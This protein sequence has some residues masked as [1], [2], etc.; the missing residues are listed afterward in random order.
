MLCRG[1]NLAKTKS[2]N[3]ISVADIIPIYVVMGFVLIGIIVNVL[4]GQKVLS[5]ANSIN[6]PWGII[7]SNFVYDGFQNILGILL[8]LLFLYLSNLSFGLK[9]RKARYISTIVSMFIGGFFANFLWFYEMLRINSTVTSTGQSG[10][11]YAFWGACFSLFL[12]DTTIILIGKVAKLSSRSS[13]NIEMLKS[14]RKKFRWMGGTASIFISI[15]VLADLYYGQKAFFTELPHINYFVHIVAFLSGMI[16]CLIV[17]LAILTK[18]K[19]HVK[20]NTIVQQ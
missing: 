13:S 2:Q 10:V 18:M 17:Y 16:V 20:D 3:T 8:F 9:L 11:V 15:I 5:L 6:T 4:F 1:L 14:S 12:F 7:T 19:I